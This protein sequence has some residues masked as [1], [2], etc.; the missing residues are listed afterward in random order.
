MI[1]AVTMQLKNKTK[2]ND[3]GMTIREI[4]VGL[5]GQVLQ[6]LAGTKMALQQLRAING[7]C[8]HVNDKFGLL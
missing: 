1:D 8:L 3:I 6:S 4:W 2:L 7:K 5:S